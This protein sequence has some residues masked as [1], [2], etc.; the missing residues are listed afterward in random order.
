MTSCTPS[1]WPNC[2]KIVQS[3]STSKHEFILDTDHNWTFGNSTI[4]KAVAKRQP[5]TTLRSVWSWRCVWFWRVLSVVVIHPSLLSTSLAP[6][7]VGRV[8]SAR[9]HAPYRPHFTLYQ[10]HPF[11]L[12]MGDDVKISGM[13]LVLLLLLPLCGCS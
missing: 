7:P 12:H 3:L 11:R 8:V 9:S 5:K 6:P 1:A 4:G 13:Y 2:R 10:P